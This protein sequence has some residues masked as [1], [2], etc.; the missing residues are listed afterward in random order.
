M[1]VAEQPLQMVRPQR[2]H[3]WRR[4]KRENWLSHTRQ[5]GTCGSIRCGGG[6]PPW[7]TGAPMDPR[8][9]IRMVWMYSIQG[10]SSPGIDLTDLAIYLLLLLLLSIVIII[11]YLS[12][13]SFRLGQFWCIISFCDQKEAERSEVALKPCLG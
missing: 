10:F 9:G 12:V 4:R 8:K 6:R 13:F 11:Y 2:R 5:F 1:G 3:Q 7:E